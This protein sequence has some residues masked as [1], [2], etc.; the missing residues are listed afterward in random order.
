MM[1]LTLRSG[2]EVLGQ[3]DCFPKTQAKP[4]K[5][6]YGM[7]RDTDATPERFR[8]IVGSQTGAED[9]VVFGGQTTKDTSFVYD[10]NGKSCIISRMDLELNVIKWARNYNVEDESSNAHG[11]QFTGMK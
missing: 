1:V 8:A 7:N 3:T 2:G 4:P 6:I 9:F 5:T 10:G 11:S